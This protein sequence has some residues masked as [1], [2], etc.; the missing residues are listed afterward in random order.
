MSRK[1]SLIGIMKAGNRCL[2][3]RIGGKNVQ[4]RI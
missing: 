1:K 2:R 4:N 3:M